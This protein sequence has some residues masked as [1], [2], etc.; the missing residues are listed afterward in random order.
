MAKE[1]NLQDFLTDVANAIREKKG[2]SDL[3]N[4]QD[5]SKEITSLA[6]GND[7]DVM[8]TIDLT[9]TI[10]NGGDVAT[11]KE[12]EEAYALFQVLANKIMIGGING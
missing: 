3:I 2:T 4:P 11:D 8:K 5:F 12:Y 1:N 6:G 10:I 9:E 7:V